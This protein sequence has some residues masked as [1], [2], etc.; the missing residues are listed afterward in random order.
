MVLAALVAAFAF[1]MREAGIFACPA[2]RLRRRRYLGYCKGTAYGDYDHGALWFGLEPGVREA[3]AAAD[4]LFVGNSRM[5]FGF[6]APPLERWF[7]ERRPQLL[8]ARLHPQRERQ[9][10]HAAAESL[11]PAARAY[12]IS[13]D[14]FFFDRIPAGRRDMHSPDARGRYHGKRAWQAPHRLLCGRCRRSA[15]R[16]SPTTGSATPA[17]SG[18]TGTR[19]LTAAP[20]EVDRPVY[21]K[22]TRSCWRP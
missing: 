12:V 11:A 14:K 3:A 10:H 16:P 19:G 2:P 6:S 21:V 22:G 4:V 15:A 7:A 9:L 13:V 17:S 20:I 5:Q 8:P 18:S 1:H